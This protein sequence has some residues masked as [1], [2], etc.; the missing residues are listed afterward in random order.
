MESEV[1]N[2]AEVLVALALRLVGVFV[3]LAFLMVS[4]QIAGA[5]ITRARQGRAGAEGGQGKDTSEGG[6]SDPAPETAAIEPKE[7]M[8][9]EEAAAAIALALDGLIRERAAASR[10]SGPAPFLAERDGAWKILGRQEALLRDAPWKDPM[11]RRA[12]PLTG[13]REP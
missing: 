12:W 3:V 13:N 11:R 9:D 4:I 1:I 8:T 2:W 6:V 7:A 5:L 10:I